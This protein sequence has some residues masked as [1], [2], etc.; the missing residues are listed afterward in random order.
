MFEGNSW[1]FKFEDL[2]EALQNHL[3]VTGFGGLL[4]GVVSAILVSRTVMIPRTVTQLFLAAIGI[5][6]VLWFLSKILKKREFDRPRWGAVGLLLL[7]YGLGAFLYE[8]REGLEWVWSRLLTIHSTPKVLLAALFLFGL[9][10]GFFV[11]RNW[12]KDQD[13]FTKSVL[14]ATGGALL[15]PLL[16]KFAEGK[17]ET[18]SAFVYYFLGFA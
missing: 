8:Y 6:I 13:D 11:V 14:A 3:A 4:L 16:G 10:M 17:V 5:V 2:L 7:R 1:K 9:I 18:F 15:T 12:S